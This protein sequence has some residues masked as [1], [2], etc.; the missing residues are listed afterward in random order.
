MSLCPSALIVRA[1]RQLCPDRRFEALRAR[2]K[3]RSQEWLK[4]AGGSVAAKLN[5]R[6][7]RAF[8]S[9]EIS[10]EASGCK[11]SHSDLSSS[12]QNFLALN[13]R[14]NV[15]GFILSGRKYAG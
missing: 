11:L 4:R 12:L 9:L 1:R 13:L 3:Q 15:A 10:N 7:P 14:P 6:E 5:H 8:I 2:S